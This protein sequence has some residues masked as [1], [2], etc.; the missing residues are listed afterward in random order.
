MI[1]QDFPIV[2]ADAKEGKAPAFDRIYRDLAPSIGGFARGRGARDPDDIISETMVSVVRGLDAFSGDEGSFRSWVFTIA[3]RRVV[4]SQRRSGRQVPTESIGPIEP[5]ARAPD[6]EEILLA[7]TDDSP[8]MQALQRLKRDQRD[9]LLL[10]IVAGL[11]VDEVAT[12]LGKR[13]SAVKMIQQRA[14][15]RLRTELQEPDL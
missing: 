14:L 4:D 1:G 11:P 5:A 6:P 8:V 3:Y 10:R 15:T 13:V 12:L 7:Q 9:V 2:L